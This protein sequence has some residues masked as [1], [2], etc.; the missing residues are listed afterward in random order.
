MSKN[1]MIVD[2]FIYT[3]M[4]CA[5]AIFIMVTIHIGM[6]FIEDWRIWRRERM[7]IKR[8]REHLKKK[9]DEQE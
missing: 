1:P 9:E 7:E 6:A 3:L 4:V 2:I 5:M 8:W